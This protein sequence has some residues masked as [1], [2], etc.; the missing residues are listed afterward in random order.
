MDTIERGLEQ[1]VDV[2]FEWL[3][4]LLG[5]LL[6]LLIG[7]WVARVLAKGTRKG[8]EKINLDNRLYEAQ[9]GSFIE[10]AIPSPAGLMSRIVY[11]VLFLGAL[12]LAVSVLG[13]DALDRLVAGI[14]GYIPHVIAALIIFLVGSAIAA[15][16][17]TLVHNTMGDTPTGKIVES[18][19]PVIVIGITVFMIL[20]QLNIAPEIVTITYAAL[21]GS[22]ALGSALAFG[23]GGRS[24]A[25]KLLEN[26]YEAGAAQKDQVKRDVRTGKNRADKKIKEARR[27][28]R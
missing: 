9:G 15:G 26:A 22:V 13:I 3:P 8:L 23:L 27:K 18:T 21:I 24:V 17:T 20:N 6:L 11:W 7:H 10:R 5:A 12:S 1:L 19:A 2:I 16:V 25:E 4:Q 14:Y 28:N